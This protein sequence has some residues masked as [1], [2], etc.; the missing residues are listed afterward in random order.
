MYAGWSREYSAQQL[1]TAGEVAETRGDGAVSER[2][3]ST[4]RTVTASTRAAT[5]PPPRPI[6]PLLLPRWPGR[7]DAQQKQKAG[8]SSLSFSSSVF[9]LFVAF[10]LLLP[11][12][13]KPQAIGDWHDLFQR[14]PY[15][16]AYS[17]ERSTLTRHRHMQL[18]FTDQSAP[19]LP[20]RARPFPDN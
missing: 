14:H 1:A 15:T 6:R 20:Y 5:K 12:T 16:S 19:H 11:A 2:L 17:L 4:N 18:S 8:P 9:L 3:C 10:C 13:F 7:D